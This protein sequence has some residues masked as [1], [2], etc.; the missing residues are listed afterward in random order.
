MGNT[1]SIGRNNKI[2]MLRGVAIILVIVGHGIDLLLQNGIMV[3]GVSQTIY[4]IIYMFHIPLFFLI[5]GYTYK[6]NRGGK[7][8]II[9]NIITF[10]IPY[11]FFNSIYWVE[12]MAAS[13]ILGIQLTQEAAEVS[14]KEIVRLCWNGEGLSWFLLSMLLVKV[15]F[16]ILDS[17]CSGMTAFLSFSVC[18]W[19]AYIFPQNQLL[20]YLGWG[21]F[22]TIGYIIHKY[23]IDKKQKGLIFVFCMNIMALGIERYYGQGLDILVRLLIGPSV[24][25]L[26]LLYAEYIPNINFLA[27]C[28]KKSIVIYMIHGL[29]QYLSFYVIVRMMNIRGGFVTLGL[30]VLI[31]LAL[32]FGAAWMSKKVKLVQFI[33][34]PYSILQN[35]RNNH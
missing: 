26:Y 4:G 24:F 27:I 33:F 34:Y 30:M 23:D 7:S 10:Y 32:S 6:S 18:F 12:K 28:G 1:D 2:D 17:Y 13:K 29:T 31:Q 5:S 25:V 11:L 16:H 3:I 35:C 14:L 8:D 22:F 9:K 15:I 21:I 20:R 19:L